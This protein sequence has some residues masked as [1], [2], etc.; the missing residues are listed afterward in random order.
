MAAT[1]QSSLNKNR[2]CQAAGYAIKWGQADASSL[3]AEPRGLK[4]SYTVGPEINGYHPVSG[5]IEVL[6]FHSDIRGWIAIK[7]DD[8]YSFDLYSAATDG[9]VG[10]LL[11]KASYPH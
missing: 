5:S 2:D 9:G 10:P 6:G 7:A 8:P 4:G 3:K 1:A 11:G